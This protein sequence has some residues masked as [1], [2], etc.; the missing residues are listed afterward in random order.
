MQREIIL[1]VQLP[2]FILE[3]TASEKQNKNNNIETIIHYHQN[4]NKD[5]NPVFGSMRA[6]YSIFPTRLPV[7]LRFIFPIYESME[8]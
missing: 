3:S 6:H 1:T 2:Q 7:S 4:E 8:P 5:L